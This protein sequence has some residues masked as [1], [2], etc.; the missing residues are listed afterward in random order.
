MVSAHVGARM[1]STHV[2]A[3]MVSTHVGARMVSTHVGADGQRLMGNR[4][5]APTVFQ[6]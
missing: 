2:G 5:L 4:C 1:V 6:A 3:R